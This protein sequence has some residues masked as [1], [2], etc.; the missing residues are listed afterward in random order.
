MNEIVEWLDK[1][2]LKNVNETNKGEIE[3]QENAINQFA[4]NRKNLDDD[5]DI[6]TTNLNKYSRN[7]TMKLNYLIAITSASGS[8]TTTLSSKIDLFTKRAKSQTIDPLKA[9]ITEAKQE[10]EKLYVDALKLAVDV[11]GYME[12]NYF[13]QRV[14]SMDI[15]RL[16]S[17]NLEEA[18]SPYYLREALEF[19]RIWD[20][21]MPIKEFVEVSLFW[22]IC[23][24]YM[25]CFI[26]II[27][28]L[29]PS[30]SFCLII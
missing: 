27:S 2:T 15:W 6:V 13:W 12:G 25:E 7:Q 21:N 14:G 18:T 20:Q 17:P 23:R 8:E 26:F 9:T 30:V 5:T 1:N 16:P 28:E 4:D 3:K 10:V 22:N 19:W 29:W 24:C 11:N